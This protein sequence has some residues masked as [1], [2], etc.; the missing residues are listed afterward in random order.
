VLLHYYKLKWV[1]DELPNFVVG[2]ANDFWVYYSSYILVTFGVPNIIDWFLGW[3]DAHRLFLRFFGMPTK[4]RIL[5][6]D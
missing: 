4:I 3:G 6:I 1:T 5:I 2:N